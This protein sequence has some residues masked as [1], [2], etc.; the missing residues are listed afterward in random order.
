MGK[1]CSMGNGDGGNLFQAWN[2]KYITY[3]FH[4]MSRQMIFRKKRLVSTGYLV[5]SQRVEKEKKHL[6]PV[7]VEMCPIL[8]TRGLSL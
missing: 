5:Y 7:N 8:E 1:A 3:S 2:I 6:Q 4:I